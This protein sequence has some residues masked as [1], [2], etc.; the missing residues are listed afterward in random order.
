MYI[1][2]YTEIEVVLAKVSAGNR[3]QVPMKIIQKEPNNG[4]VYES[5]ERLLKT[6]RRVAISQCC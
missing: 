2:K 4:I 3:W 5:A 6:R 1:Y